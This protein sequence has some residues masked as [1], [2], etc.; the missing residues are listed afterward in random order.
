MNDY[1]STY[2]Q[3]INHDDE[4]YCT[5]TDLCRVCGASTDLIEEMIAEGILSPEG[6]SPDDWRFTMVSI[7]RVQTVARLQQDLRINLPGC[8]LVLD[9]LDELATLRGMTQRN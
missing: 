9:L 2:I 6:A 8:A 1:T 5:Y 3:G 4:S 7:H